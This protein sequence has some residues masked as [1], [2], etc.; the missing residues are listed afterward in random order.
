MAMLLMSLC[1]ITVIQLT[2]SQ[3]V[4]V[5]CCERNEQ[6]LRQ[7]VTSVSQ[8]QTAIS[9]L[10]SNVG[11]LKSFNQQLQLAGIPKYRCKSKISLNRH[12]NPPLETGEECMGE[13]SESERNS[14][15]VVQGH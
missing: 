3:S 9:Q 15:I 2:S 4:D 7:L 13:V 11:Q 14:I 6:L 10:Q 5:S 12:N 1:I 8:M